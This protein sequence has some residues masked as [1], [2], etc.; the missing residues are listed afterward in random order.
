M[1]GPDNTGPSPA[2]P[3]RKQHLRF[4]YLSNN[5][6]SH[7]SFGPAPGNSYHSAHACSLHREHYDAQR[8]R[9]ARTTRSIIS[10]SRR[11]RQPASHQPAPNHTS[12]PL[13]PSLHASRLHGLARFEAHDRCSSKT[14]CTAPL[15]R[16]CNMQREVRW[17]VTLVWNQSPGDVIGL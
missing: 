9:T 7:R 4:P 11:N 1:N 15:D 8:E 6:T 14:R 2:H 13:V 3:H 12:K 16:I 10:S 17:I 5:M